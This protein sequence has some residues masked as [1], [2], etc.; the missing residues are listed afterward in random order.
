MNDEQTQ[1]IETSGLFD[2]DLQF[3]LIDSSAKIAPI[4]I[5]NTLQME[6]TGSWKD[7]VL[8]LADIGLAA[9]SSARTLESFELT[10]TMWLRPGV[11][12]KV[13]DFAP[14]IR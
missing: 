9:S 13:K 7:R 10:C 2:S 4:L 1:S 5:I 14:I 8:L 3:G 12:R 6:I 11:H